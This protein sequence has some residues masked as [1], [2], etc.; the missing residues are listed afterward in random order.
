MSWDTIITAEPKEHDVVLPIQGSMPSELLGGNYYLNGPSLLGKYDIRL[1]PFDG[2]GLLRKI[3]FNSNGAAFK[4]RYVQTESYLY[5]QKA[6]KVRYRGIGGLPYNS[7]L[8]NWWSKEVKN[9]ANTCVLPWQGKIL[10]SYEGGWPYR[11]D[12][13]TLETRG[14]ESFSNTL[15]KKVN[16][17]AHTRYDARKKELFGVSFKPGKHSTFHIHGY[18]ED[19]SS[20]L[21][22]NFTQFG[23][24]LIHD[25]LLTDHF[26]II[27]E[28]PIIPEIPI[29][30]K[31]MAGLDSVMNAVKQQDRP[32]RV[33]LFP[34]TGGD[35][36]VIEM[37][38]SY[39]G[40]HH[41]SA[42][43][44]LDED[45]KPVRLIL[46][47]CLF[48]QYIDFGHEFGYTGN[49][50]PYADHFSKDQP[51]QKLS[52]IEV[53][54]NS[55]TCSVEAIT[56]WPLDF[57]KIHPLG[58]GRGCT[59]IYGTTSSPKG[60]FNPFDTLCQVNTKTGQTR[61]WISDCGYLGEAYF[62]PSGDTEEFGFLLCM[63]YRPDGTDLLVLESQDF[64]RGPIARI[65]LPEAFPY[66]F[67]G[68]FEAGNS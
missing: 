9:P 56:D 30:I 19:G 3:S 38:K 48:D 42:A 44:I 32:A 47:S 27:I 46:H 6:G 12:P 51:P 31:A 26:V 36:K 24:T 50:T 11:L 33:M 34:R 29:L 10:C 8:K 2:H 58:D 59:H 41:A 28:N 57:P 43:E 23:M 13:S 4:S 68:F 18:A 39:V 63:A 67:H 52:K 35:P 53:D 45:G 16:F 40:F 25:F 14:L 60:T 65:P 66:G 64:E 54:L 62:V 22:H 20:V 21:Q 5:E 55:N 49:S 1:H 37:D 17:L 7:P 15:V 61:T